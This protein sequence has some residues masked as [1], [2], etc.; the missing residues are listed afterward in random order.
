MHKSIY[1]WRAKLG[2]IVPPTNTV[3]EAEWARLMPDGV[4]FHAIRMKLHADT[5]SAEGRAALHRDLDAAM[6]SVAQARVDVI[7]Y[8]CTAG[9]MSLPLD[10]L[11]ERMRASSGIAAVTTASAIVN[12]LRALGVRRL[13]VATPYH[14][15]LN[16]HEAAFLSACGF[17]VL[18]I[19]GLG[20]GGGGPHE[21]VRLAETALDTIREQAGR[22][23]RPGAE[24]LLVSC[25][26]Y[27]ALTLVSELEA[28][29]GMPVVTSNTA[30]LW[31]SLRAAGIGDAI[32]A[33]GRLLSTEGV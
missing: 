28:R 8:A 11:S 19:E 24:A 17:E 31:A 33:G 26:D 5:E 10:G 15:A 3:N 22:V 14:D 20:I 7:A 2:V 21:Y 9:S 27:P 23:M 29:F 6:A 25:T 1:S 30:T 12:G 4:T 32:A 18:A 16:Q 13:V